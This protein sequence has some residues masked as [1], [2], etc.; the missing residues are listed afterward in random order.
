MIRYGKD[1]GDAAARKI[2]LGDE[3]VPGQVMWDGGRLCYNGVV[4]EG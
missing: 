3:S 1:Y 4:D 2:G